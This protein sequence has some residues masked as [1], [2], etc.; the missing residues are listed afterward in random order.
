MTPILRLLAVLTALLFGISAYSQTSQSYSIVIDETSISPV[1]LDPVTGLAIDKIGLDR[2]NRPC[3]RIKLHINRMTKE[4]INRL[5]VRV[6]NGNVQL[7]KAPVAIGGDGLIIEMT[8]R[9]GV[10]FFLRHPELGDSNPVTVDLEPNKEYRMEAWEDV[11]YPVSVVCQTEGAEVYFDDEYMGVISREHIL[12]LPDVPSGLHALRVE[13]GDEKYFEEVMVSSSLATFN[14]EL[15]DKDLLYGT[16]TFN[17]T[18]GTASLEIDGE[19]LTSEDGVINRRTAFGRYP[20]KV[21]SEGYHQAEGIVIIDT[22]NVVR[23]ISL[24]PMVTSLTLNASDDVKVMI[25]GKKVSEGTWTG[26]LSPGTY[27]VKTKKT[28]HYPAFSTLT[29][30]PEAGDK[31]AF[32]TPVPSVPYEKNL[33]AQ[34]SASV[35]PRMSCGVML[36]YVQT[37][38]GYVKFRSNFNSTKGLYN[39]ASDLNIEGGGYFWPSGDKAESVMNVSGGMLLRATKSLYPYIGVGYGSRKMMWQDAG[40]KWANITDYTYTGISAEAGL[41]FKLGPVALS[42]GVS[43]TAF[44]YTAAE[45]G[46]GVML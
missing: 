23:T 16:L 3:A 38:G 34:V 13:Y 25:D 5:E 37:I 10:M 36:G 1:N 12:T 18:P 46:I 14:V 28:N 41:I 45:V 35:Y 39:A 31:M 8:A 11:R 24:K 2:S 9:P 33:L 19:T 32:D 27:E 43:T 15:K 40:G 22:T 29:I 4:E 7:V 17:L 42:A 26:N 21:S 30:T 44:K 20:Y 6:I